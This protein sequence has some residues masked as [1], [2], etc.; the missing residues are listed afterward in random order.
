MTTSHNQYF[1]LLIAN[2]QYDD[3]RVAADFLCQ[4]EGQSHHQRTFDSDSC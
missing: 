1:F 2:N 3:K 4:R